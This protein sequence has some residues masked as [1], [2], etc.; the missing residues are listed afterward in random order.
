M[1]SEL[2]KW[3]VRALKRHNIAIKWDKNI[4]GTLT[5]GYNVS[6]GFRSIKHE[7][8]KRVINV[9][10]AAYERDEIVRHALI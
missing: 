3:K 8:E 7:V 5:E 4:V 6:Y 10:A 9:I 1:N 2:H